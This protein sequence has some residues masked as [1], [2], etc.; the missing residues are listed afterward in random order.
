MVKLQNKKT[1]VIK[2]I[3]K[4]FEASMYLGTGEWER[5]EEKPAQQPKTPIIDTKSKDEK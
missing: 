3:E 2:E 5:V 4:E 1:K